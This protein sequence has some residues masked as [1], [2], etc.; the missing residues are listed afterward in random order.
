MS[1]IRVTG[2]GFQPRHLEDAARLV[3]ESIAV[4]PYLVKAT[5]RVAISADVL[6]RRVPADIGI[7]K[8]DGPDASVL[9]LGAD[10]LEWIAGRLVGYGFEFEVV[11]PPELRQYLA[12]LG[13][14]LVS[15]H[16]PGQVPV[17]PRRGRGGGGPSQ[18][19]SW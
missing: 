7:V 15:A 5:I 8:A 14:R 18:H 12:E 19:P 2:H 13:T 4:A 1:A 3:A 17:A 16:A 10:D 6:I 11:D 9:T